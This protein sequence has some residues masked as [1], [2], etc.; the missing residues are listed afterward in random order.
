MNDGS[1]GVYYNDHT[2]MVLDPSN[3][4]VEYLEK[5]H[6]DRVDVMTGYQVSE[7]PKELQKKMM[8]MKHFKS[9]LQADKNKDPI[10]FDESQKQ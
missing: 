3:T 9:Y 5:Q 6:H 8:L 4:Y 10:L 7:C 1:F 2:K